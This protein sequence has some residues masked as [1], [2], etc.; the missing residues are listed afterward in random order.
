MRTLGDP[1]PIEPFPQVITSCKQVIPW[2]GHSVNQLPAVKPCTQAVAATAMAPGAP[3]QAVQHCGQHQITSS[4]KAV[5]A[6]DGQAGQAGQAKIIQPEIMRLLDEIAAMTPAYRRTT[7]ERMYLQGKENW[8]EY[9][10]S[11]SKPESALMSAT[12]S[13][14]YAAVLGDRHALKLLLQIE[15]SGPSKA[16]PLI[17]ERIDNLIQILGGLRDQWT[18]NSL[19][20]HLQTAKSEGNL[21]LTI[22][23]RLQTTLHTKVVKGHVGAAEAL[24]IAPQYFTCENKNQASKRPRLAQSEFNRVEEGVAKTLLE[25]SS[26]KRRTMELGQGNN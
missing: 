18:A 1:M 15:T 14:T 23:T 8:C 3:L 13:L 20:A 21:P 17:H 22:L 26:T 12:G 4:P 2:L 11:M 10:N 19:L 25:L 7:A 9:L 16:K 5:I 24:L 6:G